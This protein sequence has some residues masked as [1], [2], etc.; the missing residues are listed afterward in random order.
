M[1]TI[2]ETGQRV[3]VNLML[4]LAVQLMQIVSQSGGTELRIHH[5]NH[6]HDPQNNKRDGAD[7]DRKF[8]RAET[9]VRSVSKMGERS[10]S[11]TGVMHR[12]YCQR[13]NKGS[14]K[15]IY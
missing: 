10:C 14:N 9:I 6:Q 5:R 11:H 7:P 15:P 4:K 8:Q 3:E 13:H 1:R 2:S 12:G